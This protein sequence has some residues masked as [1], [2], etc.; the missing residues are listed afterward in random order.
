MR[1]RIIDTTPTPTPTESSQHN[2]LKLEELATVEVSSEDPAFPVE[3]VFGESRTGWRAAGTG[4]QVLRLIFDAPTNLS[5]IQLAFSETAVE[6]TQEFTLRWEHDNAPARE[7]VRQQW[8]FSPQ[9]STSE[10]EDYSVDLQ[11]VRI[12][13][14]TIKPDLSPER[15]VASLVHWRVA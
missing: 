6:R 7:I 11:A 13:E 1:K 15:A 14:L 9:G 12:L 4:Q 2:W 5:H 8:G 10:I 3:N